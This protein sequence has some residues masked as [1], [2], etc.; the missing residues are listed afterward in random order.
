VFRRRSAHIDNIPKFGKS[1]RYDKQ[2]DRGNPPNR[3]RR[4]FFNES[5]VVFQ[6][7][8][9]KIGKDQRLESDT[10]EDGPNVN[11][12]HPN[13][14]DRKSKKKTQAEDVRRERGDFDGRKQTDGFY[15]RLYGRFFLDWLRAVDRLTRLSILLPRT[16]LF[17]IHSIA[18]DTAVQPKIHFCPSHFTQIMDFLGRI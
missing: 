11:L 15:K 4:T 18:K 1:L 17:N 16:Q 5:S 8:L 10:E 12:R 14:K 7:K 13:S 3:E 6:L 9:L 2:Y